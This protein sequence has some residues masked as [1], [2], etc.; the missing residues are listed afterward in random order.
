MNT[1]DVGST[2]IYVATY[3]M[4]YTYCVEYYEKIEITDLIGDQTEYF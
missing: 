3:Y 1:N 2:C 4:I